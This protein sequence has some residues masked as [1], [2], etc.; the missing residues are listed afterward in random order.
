ESEEHNV[1]D[2]LVEG[3]VVADD[4]LMERY[5]GD[6]TIDVTE[7]SGALAVGVAAGAVFPVLCGSATKVVGV[8]R[9]GHFI[10][11][12]APAPGAG[13]GPPVAF[14]FKTIVDAY[15]GRVNLFKVLQGTVKTDATLVNGRTVAEERLHQISI[16]RGKEQE[17]VSE[18]PPGDIAAV[19]KLTD[20]TT[21]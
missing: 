5:L 3:I 17:A 4:D 20:T 8:D 14:V 6:E 10:T 18:V 15:V 19:A 13:D 9:L 21:G 7:L 2:A 1:H 11:A 16:I 12:V